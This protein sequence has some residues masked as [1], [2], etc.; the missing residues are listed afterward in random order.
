MFLWTEDAEHSDNLYINR[1]QGKVILFEM[2]EEHQNYSGFAH[3][4]KTK[5]TNSAEHAT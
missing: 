3:N 1:L 2:C 5:K 4:V